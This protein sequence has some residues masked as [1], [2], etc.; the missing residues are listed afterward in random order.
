[1]NCRGQT[2]RDHVVDQLENLPLRAWAC[3]VRILVARAYKSSM[4]LEKKT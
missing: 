1:M 2:I 3:G 4:E